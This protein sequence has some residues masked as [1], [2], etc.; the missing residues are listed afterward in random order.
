MKNFIQPGHNLTLIAEADL[1]GGQGLLVGA[2]FGVVQGDAAE[3]EEFVLCRT[4]V[5]DMPKEAGAAWVVGD[6]IYW[7]DAADQMT[8]TAADN[9]LVGAVVLDAAEADVL[10]A[11]LLDGVIRAPA[12][13][14]P[15]G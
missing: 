10:G 14:I 15:A 13:E 8:L 4:G 7:D 1:V 9:T 3:G 2:L 11:V 12:A 5:Y 6:P